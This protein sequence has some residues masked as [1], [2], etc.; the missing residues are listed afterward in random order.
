MIAIRMKNNIPRV[1]G[2]L[3]KLPN[4]LDK[5]AETI[6]KEWAKWVQK[7]AK[8]APSF[9]GTLKANIKAEKEK[10]KKGYKTWIVGV[11]GKASRY[12]RYVERGWTPHWIPIDYIWQHQANPGQKGE[13]VDNPSGWV[14]SHSNN[15]DT[16]FLRKAVQASKSNIPN[17]IQ[18]A[19]SKNIG[20]K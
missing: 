4:Q 7:A 20:G 3:I 15:T 16:G 1:S 9:T 6:G 5:S 13:Y 8:R 17:I 10:S 12:G 11:F 19:L 14:L 18:K 2:A